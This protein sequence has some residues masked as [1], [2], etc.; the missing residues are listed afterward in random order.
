M[1]NGIKMM[2]HNP[3]LEGF[4]PTP[5]IS[6]YPFCVLVSLHGLAGDPPGERPGQCLHHPGPAAC[7]DH[8]EAGKDRLHLFYTWTGKIQCK[9]VFCLFHL[10]YCCRLVSMK[11]QLTVLPSLPSGGW[12]SH[13]KWKWPR[14]ILGSASPSPQGQTHL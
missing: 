1:P 6:C 5:D 14:T 8:Q 9:L 7:H 10:F 13:F 12:P 2:G 3:F 4:L 11:T